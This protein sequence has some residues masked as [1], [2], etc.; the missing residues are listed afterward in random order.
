M[1]RVTASLF[2]VIIPLLF[3]SAARTADSTKPERLYEKLR[4]RDKESKREAVEFA[5]ERGIPVR[6]KAAGN[7]EFEIMG[8][9]EGPPLYYIT[10]NRNASITTRTDSVLSFSSGGEGFRLGIWDGG[11]VR[12]THREFQGRVILSGDANY[13]TSTHSTHV[14]GTMIAAGL[15]SL[16]R[17]MAPAAELISYEWNNDESEVAEAAANGLL[18]SNHSY[19]FVRGWLKYG[20]WYWYGDVNIDQNEDYLFGFYSNRSRVWDEVANASPNCLIVVSAGNDRGDGPEPGTDHLYWDSGTNGWARSTRVRELDGGDDG[21]DCL[22]DGNSVAKNLLVV[23]AVEDFVPVPDTSAVEMTYFSGWGP[24]DDGR[25][26]PDICGNGWRLYSCSDESDSDYIIYSGTSMASPN[27]SGTLGLLHDYYSDIHDGRKLL[28][29]T[30]KALA[31]HTAREAGEAK[32]PD[33]R[34]GWG[35]LD[36]VEAG[37]V[38]EEDASSGSGLIVELTLLEGSPLEFQVTGRESG[39]D[40]R[41]TICWNDP[42]GEVPAAALNS[43]VSVLV[44]DLDLRVEGAGNTYHPWV[45]DPDNPS[46]PA[47][48]DDNAVD[49]VEQVVVENPGSDVYTVRIRHKGSLKDGKQEFSLIASGIGQSRIIRVLEDGSGDAPD[50]GSALE[51]ARDGNQIL[52]YPGNYYESGLVLDKRILL[53]GVGGPDNTAITAHDGKRC[54]KVSPEAEGSV[55]EGFALAGGKRRDS[56]NG[57]GLLIGADS[58]SVRD[59]R[60]TSCYGEL[61]GGIYISGKS[62]SLR[63]CVISGCEASAGGAIYIAGGDADVQECRITGNM[64][65]VEAGGVYI[66][67]SFPGLENCTIADNLSGGRAGGIYLNRSSRVEM[68]NNIIAFNEAAGICSE[69]YG[70]YLIIN[71][72][73]IY[74]NTTEFM[75]DG[76]EDL[77]HTGGNISE[78]PVFC[79]REDG[80]YTIGDSSPCTENSSLCGEIIGSEEVGC[81]TRSVTLVK[82]DGSGDTETIQ[83][84]LDA[85]VDGDT[86]YLAPGTFSGDGNRDISTRGK[87]VVVIS[88]NGPRETI[89]DCSTS[90]G[91][92]SGFFFTGGED[93]ST[94]IKGV[95]ITGAGAGGIWCDGSNPSILD[96]VISDNIPSVGYRGG[97]VYLENSSPKI[98][99]CYITGNLTGSTGGGIFCT[100]SEPVVENCI[101][102]GNTAC[103]NGGGIDLKSGSSLVIT[104]SEISDNIS[105][106]G[107]GGGLNTVMSD[108]VISGCRITGNRTTESGGGIFNGTNSTME[109]ENSLVSGNRSTGMAGGIYAGSGII[110]TGCTITSNYAP[111]YGSGIE[112]VSGPSAAIYRSVIAFNEGSEGL[113]SII[114]DADISCSDLFGNP[115]GNYGGGGSDQTGMNGNISADPQFCDTLS[116][117]WRISTASPCMPGGNGCG[118]LMGA[119]GAGC[120]DLPDLTVSAPVFD[121]GIPVAGS[122]CRLSL[123][124]R[125]TGTAA[126][127]TVTVYIYQ[128]PENRPY[129]D[130]EPRS[131]E[132]SS[133]AAGDSVRLE[134]EIFRT[135]PGVE[136]I[137]L[138]LDP[139]DLVNES[140]EDNNTAGP[141]QLEWV[142]EDQGFPEYT[143]LVNIYPNPSR[144][145]VEIEYQLSVREAPEISIFDTAG[146]VIRKWK[147]PSLAPGEYT[148]HWNGRNRNG[149]KVASGIY[150]V[151]FVASGVDNSRKA[152]IIR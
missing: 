41:I 9:T 126:A 44:N 98:S 148:L 138:V 34:F 134:L 33:Y 29:S 128:N 56:G 18:I 77:F 78:D 64:A 20:S 88:V 54:L 67:N 22:P 70:G 26:K 66:D 115:E 117:D 106:T 47:V 76:L 122:S 89:I 129:G 45:L 116:G 123:M 30:V 79:G 136:D 143:G 13:S 96:C 94:V 28:G 118:I 111:L 14:G 46:L 62:P 113:Y 92:Y 85:A 107:F 87:S 24:T 32:G 142:S 151:R 25:I 119:Y 16:A 146:R 84:A 68:K 72:C 63:E 36:A 23:G 1:K 39:E 109:I 65:S 147:G 149:I 135:E 90:Q 51:M 80:I 35:L 97:G 103:E 130:T 37:R 15:D 100:G 108:A 75:G 48:R 61:G 120:G 53:K 95:K 10:F 124:A 19:G 73:N 144:E 83:E 40:I 7:R 71:C 31:I 8:L 38:I 121:P 59:C 11:H 99:G 150:I 137:Y 3:F 141:Y 2:L 125:N 140:G 114:G 57:G 4:N 74:G 133:L 93:S 69:S 91:G 81:H 58:V 152:V 145:T 21:Y 105:E 49:N 127:D 60:I 139:E 12:T 86:I 27:V 110:I 55:I 82:P 43:R 52:V 112:C 17:G 132:S 42:A 104:G 131:L 5:E 50:I 102:N 6:G 101:I